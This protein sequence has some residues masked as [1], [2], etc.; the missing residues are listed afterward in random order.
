MIVSIAL[1]LALSRVPT[2][3]PSNAPIPRNDKICAERLPYVRVV[4]PTDTLPKFNQFTVFQRVVALLEK[5]RYTEASGVYHYYFDQTLGK[6]FLQGSPSTNFL[7]AGRTRLGLIAL[8]QDNFCSDASHF[9]PYF[10]DANAVAPFEKDLE[11]AIRGEYTAAY[12]DD[13]LACSRD[14]QFSYPDIVTGILCEAN[15]DR[16]CARNHWI[17]AAAE[18]GPALPETDIYPDRFVPVQL[19]LRFRP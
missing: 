3:T 12:A 14:C 15:G 1:L 2:N 10:Y 13:D 11:E 7:I 18:V 9:M 17:R 8:Y 16:V 19:L 4:I 6:G 5:G